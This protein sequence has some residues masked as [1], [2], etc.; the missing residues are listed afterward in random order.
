MRIT[1]VQGAFLPVPPLLGG[2]VEKIWLALGQEFARRGHQVTHIS[3]AYP[4]LATRETLN[5]VNHR[6]LSGFAAPASLLKLKILDLLYSLRVRLHLPA[7]DIL[8]TNTFWLPMLVRNTS[9]G[10]LYVHVARYPKGQL[11]FYAHA[12][13]LQTVSKP[14]AREMAAQAPAL[15]AKIKVIPNL[16][17]LADEASV[18]ADSTQT[19]ERV[20]LYAGRIHPEKGIE[21]L[22]EA[23][24]LFCVRSTGEKWRLRLV[25]PWEH[26]QGGGGAGYQESLRSR[27]AELGE[28]VEWV[29]P[30]FDTAGLADCYRQASLFVYPSLAERG[31]TFGVAPLEAMSLGCP[32]LV[33]ALE[34]FQD[35]IEDGVTGFIFDHRTPQPAKL[36]A[37]KIFTLTRDPV[38]LREVASRASATARDYRP[39]RVAEMFLEDFAS[40]LAS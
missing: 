25:G 18:V 26:R 31:E 40:L 23:F 14:I 36:L 28:R 9:N 17:S 6:R 34:C 37:E 13:R 22:L 35:F 20:L 5:G 29:G 3:R 33:S 15:K 1:I 19:R 32:P 10:K 11:K 38:R 30:I 8:V 16:V 24:A 2:A 7:A 27:Y 39:E 4:G 21:L 12:A